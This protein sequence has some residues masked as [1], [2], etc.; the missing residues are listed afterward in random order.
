ME[1]EKFI[2]CLEAVPDVDN[3]STTEVIKTLENIALAQDI[4]SIYKSCD[5]IEG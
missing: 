5:T 4:T 1:I 3:T 2:Y